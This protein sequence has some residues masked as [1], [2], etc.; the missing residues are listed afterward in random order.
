MQKELLDIN[1]QQKLLQFTS[2]QAVSN[3]D[4][5]TMYTVGCP[6]THLS[7][8]ISTNPPKNMHIALKQ[9]MSDKRPKKLSLKR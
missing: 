8:A 9:R 4:N 7:F 2:N 6:K 3:Q 5:V 1:P